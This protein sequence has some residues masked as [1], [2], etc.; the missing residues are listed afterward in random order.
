MGTQKT[1]REEVEKYVDAIMSAVDELI[2]RVPEEH[3]E[4]VMEEID[5]IM[6]VKYCGVEGVR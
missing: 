5:R 6:R 3:R 2:A 1:G 4:A